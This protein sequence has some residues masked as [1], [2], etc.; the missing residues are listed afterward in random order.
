MPRLRL[1]RDSTAR[2]R[3][4]EPVIEAAICMATFRPGAVARMIER[5]ECQP[6]DHPAVRAHPSFFRGLIPLEEVNDG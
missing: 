6:L 2:G 5:G 4:V 1:R 3:A